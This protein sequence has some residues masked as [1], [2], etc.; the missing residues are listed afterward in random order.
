MPIYKSVS[1]KLFHKYEHLAKFYAKK[2]FNEHRIGMAQEDLEQEFRLKLF[3]VILAYG[4][5]LNRF[6]DT[7]DRKPIPLKFYIKSSLNKFKTDFIAKIESE[8][9]RVVESSIHT[10]S[11][12]YSTFNDNIIKLDYLK[13][14]F[15]INGFNLLQGLE[16]KHKWAFILFCKGF[17]ID[18]LT[19]I[20]G[21]DFNVKKIITNQR[22]FLKSNMHLFCPENS[23]EYFVKQF[24]SDDSLV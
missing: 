2:L 13:G 3:E 6:D 1:E 22:K 16:G 11:F 20:F 19:A 15:V 8:R 12:D 10:V 9:S 21:A 7:G 18:R 5:S 14:E 24:A 23:S 17:D 4:R